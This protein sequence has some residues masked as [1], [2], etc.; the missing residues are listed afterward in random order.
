MRLVRLIIGVVFKPTWMP[1]APK[2][3]TVR[4][5]VT[6]MF[7]AHTWNARCRLVVSLLMF[8]ALLFS[9]WQVAERF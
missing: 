5:T 4:E 8:A 2:G 1:Q 9:I 3:E 7:H 6:L